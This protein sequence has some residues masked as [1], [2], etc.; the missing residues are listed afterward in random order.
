MALSRS[1]DRVF[2]ASVLLKGLDGALEVIGGV[3]FLLV[4]PN[5]L[6]GIVHTLTQHELSQD[7]RDFIARHLVRSAGGLSHGTTVY[8]AIYLLSHGFAKVVLVAAVL[9]EHLWAYPA[10]M[11]LLLGFIVYQLYRLSVSFTVGLALLTVFDVF[12][13]GLTW[14]EYQDKR[15]THGSVAPST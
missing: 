3:I 14:R 2:R 1:L 15:H 13:V 11:A 5:R 4:T 7:P 6:Q 10:M 12:V 8:A 9:R